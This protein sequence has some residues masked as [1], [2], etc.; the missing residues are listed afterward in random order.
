MARFLRP[1]GACLFL[2]ALFTAVAGGLV[3]GLPRAA[4]NAAEA[5]PSSVRG[6]VSPETGGRVGDER[7]GFVLAVEAGSVAVSTEVRVTRRSEPA[8][9]PLVPGT[10]FDVV[11][12]QG[13]ISVDRFLKPVT[14]TIGF[15][16]VDLSPETAPADLFVVT[17]CKYLDRWAAVPTRV[18]VRSGIAE[19]RTVLG[20]RFALACMPYVRVMPDVAG[21]WAEE[22]VVALQSLGIVSGC[23]DGTF[24]PDAVVSRAEFVTLVGSAVGLEPVDPAESPLDDIAGHWAAGY[25]EACRRAGLLR[26]LAGPFRPDDP[27]TRA[28]MAVVLGRAVEVAPFDVSTGFEDDASIPR[29]ARGYVGVLRNMGILTGKPGNVFEPF[30]TGTRA[31]SVKIVWEILMR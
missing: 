22:F 21:H 13:D 24:R 11:A 25:I 15:D 6:L 10:A 16:P 20:K 30:G 8:Q 17:Y 19:G 23:S 7:F 27:I 4:G 26:E 31:E 14:V 28:E 1:A 12:T 9:P 18:D 29:W 3:A 2:A 5:A